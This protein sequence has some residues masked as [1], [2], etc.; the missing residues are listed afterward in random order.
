MT[1]KRCIR[2]KKLQP[3]DQFYKGSTASG[4]TY[5]SY[6]KSCKYVQGQARKHGVSEKE[7]RKWLESKRCSC[8]GRRDRKLVLDH[9][10]TTGKI[11]GIL[12]HNC[13]V[14]F[15]LLGED[16]T[17]VWALASYLDRADPETAERLAEVQLALLELFAVV[18]DVFTEDDCFDEA[19][20]RMG[21]ARMYRAWKEAR[22]VLD[23]GFEH[24]P[25]ERPKRWLPQQVKAA[26]VRSRAQDSETSSSGRKKISATKAVAKRGKR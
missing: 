2:C 19:K 6:C 1:K 23:P 14:A 25:D 11:R 15:G 5:S 26:K 18:D 7:I 16:P 4:Q 10:H 17:W 21:Y 8:C 12:C 13:N 20:I 22:P 24:V 3:V 9:N